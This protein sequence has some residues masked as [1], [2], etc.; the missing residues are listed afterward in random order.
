MLYDTQVMAREMRE[1]VVLHVKQYF[2]EFCILSNH[3]GGNNFK[4]SAVY[5]AYMSRT[6][7]YSNLYDF[8][9]TGQILNYY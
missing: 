1:E 8:L 4:T 9:A 3:R 5:Y 2:D 6:Y 7:T